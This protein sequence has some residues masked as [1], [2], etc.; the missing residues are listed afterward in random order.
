MCHTGL[1]WYSG[2]QAK[3]CHHTACLVNA[4]G[5]RGTE[6][7]G[8]FCRQWGATRIILSHL[9]L[10][11]GRPSQPPA[12]FC[13]SHFSSHPLRSTSSAILRLGEKKPKSFLSLKKKKKGK[14]LHYEDSVQCSTV[15]LAPHPALPQRQSVPLAGFMTHPPASPLQCRGKGHKLEKNKYQGLMVC[16]EL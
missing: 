7:A 5:E 8:L 10:P 2:T 6:T 12:R 13:T 3:C 11:S 4:P 14:L 1:T 16:A 15:T 9:P